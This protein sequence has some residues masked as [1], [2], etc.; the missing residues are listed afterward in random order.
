M[1]KSASS[2]YGTALNKF[3]VITMVPTGK[4]Y[5]DLY[6]IL[7]K[8]NWSISRIREDAVMS[9]G[10]PIY[11]DTIHLARQFLRV[12][13]FKLPKMLV[14]FDQKKMEEFFLSEAKK[15]KKEILK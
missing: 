6:M 4:D 15:L 14:P 10:V 13:E 12:V 3:N 2:L 7:Q 11:V 9:L 1:K 5:A 8:T